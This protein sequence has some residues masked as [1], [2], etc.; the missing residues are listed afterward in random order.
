MNTAPLSP[1]VSLLGPTGL[2]AASRS[3]APDDEAVRETAREFEALLLKQLVSA[4]RATTMTEEESGGQLVDHLLEDG[5]ASHLARS[6]GIGLGDYLTRDLAPDAEAPAPS[7]PLSPQSIP[8]AALIGRW[9][10]GFNAPV[11]S[12][13][14]AT[15]PLVDTQDTIR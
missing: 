6:G 10:G 7:R 13:D 14:D 9:T 11:P 12:L 8:T 1:P 2:K 5:L 4:M 3:A 15:E